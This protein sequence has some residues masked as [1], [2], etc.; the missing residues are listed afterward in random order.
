MY[1][2]NTLHL[3]CLYTTRNLFYVYRNTEENF[4]KFY[5]FTIQRYC[6][7][8]LHSRHVRK[9]SSDEIS[10]LFPFLFVCWKVLRITEQYVLGAVV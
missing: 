4:L 10:F 3:I 9:T 7:G 6:H 8:P 5:Y 1:L 2:C